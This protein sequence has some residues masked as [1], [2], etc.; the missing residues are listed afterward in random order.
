MV[1]AKQRALVL[2]IED[3]LYSKAISLD[4]N[5]YFAMMQVVGRRYVYISV[6]NRGATKVVTVSES[7]SSRHD[8]VCGHPSFPSIY[9]LH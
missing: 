1:A 2:R 5:G 9:C 8:T 3:R 4:D 7:V 6:E